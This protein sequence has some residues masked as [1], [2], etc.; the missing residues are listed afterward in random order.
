MAIKNI[1]AERDEQKKTYENIGFSQNIF[2][3]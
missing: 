3:K 1:R 2:A